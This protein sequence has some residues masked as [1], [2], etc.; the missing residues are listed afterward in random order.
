MFGLVVVQLHVFTRLQTCNFAVQGNMHTLSCHSSCESAVLSCGRNGPRTQGLALSQ[1]ARVLLQWVGK[2]WHLGVLVQ[3]QS[4]VRYHMTS[5]WPLLENLLLCYLSLV[6]C[7]SVV[8]VIVL[9]KTYTCK[10]HGS[11]QC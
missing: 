11:E 6:R 8:Y 3:A 4:Q 9:Q 2:P 5:C 1:R 10:R 7:L